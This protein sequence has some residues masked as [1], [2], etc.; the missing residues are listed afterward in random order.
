[1]INVTELRTEFEAAPRNNSYVKA[2]SGQLGRPL[3]ASIGQRFE[4]PISQTGE[5]FL[6]KP[7]DELK[8]DVF[9]NLQC[10]QLTGIYRLNKAKLMEMFTFSK[11]IVKV[12]YSINSTTS[13]DLII[14]KYFLAT[15]TKIYFAIKIKEGSTRE[16]DCTIYMS[17]KFFI[18]FPSL[19]N[20]FIIIIGNFK[21]KIVM[22]EEIEDLII[23]GIEYP[24]VRSLTEDKQAKL[25]I[26]EKGLEVV[27]QT[28]F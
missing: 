13:I 18:D 27:K 7:A 28:I 22:Q 5:I 17:T 8:G 25:A 1:M 19:V 15:P 24:K 9:Y 20:D 26:L 12:K 10:R 16:E 6:F 3:S 14:A 21:G 23:K 4:I 11:N 2:Y